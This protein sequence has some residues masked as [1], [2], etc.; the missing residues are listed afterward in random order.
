MKQNS[1]YLPVPFLRSWSSVLQAF[2]PVLARPDGMIRL[3][4]DHSGQYWGTSGFL[5]G[6]STYRRVSVQQKNGT[7]RLYYVHRLVARTFCEKQ[8]RSFTICHHKNN[9]RTDNRAENLEWT[10]P[11]IN[12]MLKLNARL[13]RRDE[14]TGLFEIFFIF[15][16]VEQHT[17][18]R[19][20]S[21]R[22][23]RQAGLRLRAEL[24]RE[25]RQKIIESERV[26]ETFAFLA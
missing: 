2:Q 10:T 17:D 18:K 13:H 19:F 3:Y 16:G 5:S 4:S 7:K 12:S 21:R 20:T 24:C 15:K 11:Q 6:K 23:A 14:E 9:K 26:F 1:E 22:A 25:E 8:S